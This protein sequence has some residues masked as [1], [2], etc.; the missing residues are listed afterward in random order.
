MYDYIIVG[1]GSAGAVLANRLSE[2]HNVLLLEAGGRDWPFDFRLHMPAALSEVLASSRYNWHYWTSPEPGLDHR[3]LFCPRGRVLGGSSSINGMIFVRGHPE[4][5]NR[6]AAMPG[7]SS[8]TYEQCLPYFKQSETALF[9]DSLYRGFSGPLKISRGNLDS[10]LAQAWLQAGQEA[11]FPLTPD[12]NGASQEGVGPFDRTISDGSRQSTARAYLHPVLSRE[13]LTVRT[14]VLVSR[15]ISRAGRVTGVELQAGGRLT[16]L[17][18]SKEVILCAGA[19]NSPQ[20]LM[21]SGIGDADELAKLGIQPVLNLPGVGRNLQDH[22]EVYVQYACQQ[23]VSVYPATRW[24]TKPLVGLKWLLTRS[25]AGATNHFESGAFLRS[26]QAPGYPDLQF[27]FLPVAMDYD[28]KQAYRGHGFQVHVGP[29]KPTSRGSVTLRSGD[30]RDAPLLQFNYHST[31]ADRQ[32]MRDGIRLVQEIVSRPAFSGLR[33]EMLRPLPG[34]SSDADLD[35]FVRA[36]GES[37]YHPSGT[38]RMGTDDQAVV[39]QQGRVHGLS[40]LRVVDASI[41]PEVTNGNL[42]APVIMMA[43]KIA[44]GM[45]GVRT[46]S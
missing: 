39:D 41:M 8:W 27:H 24:H 14:S 45:T 46:V 37:A 40:G 19:I 32:V 30:P 38:C 29:M 3:S 22:L 7:L 1:A 28:G 11:G 42:N 15:L 23:P 25:G 5:F 13:Q 43:E 20:L 2:N 36:H 21:L 10:P 31:E 6:W 33:G 16:R 9:G 26:G 4:D 35:A 12:F 17:H 34:C 18:A 44:A